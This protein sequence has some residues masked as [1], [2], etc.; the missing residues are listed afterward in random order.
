MK[1]P[2]I[3]ILDIAGSP[4]QMGHT[5]GQAFAEEIRHY[6]EERIGLVMSGLWSG[7]PLT[8]ADVVDIAESMLPAHE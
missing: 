8:R 2:P 7:G 1:R 3:R 4:E 6:T 5:H